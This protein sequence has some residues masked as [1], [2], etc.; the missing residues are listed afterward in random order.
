MPLA[1]LQEYMKFCQSGPS[2]LPKNSKVA[3]IAR[4]MQKSPVGS[5]L[6]GRSPA[7]VESPKANGV[8]V[9]AIDSD[10]QDGIEEQRRF[11]L[12]SLITGFKFAKD[13]VDSPRRRSPSVLG[14]EGAAM[15]SPTMSRSGHA[16]L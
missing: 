12:R 11:L 13:L 15:T 9:L 3:Q 7:V 6:R 5:P 1:D 16:A 8:A 4:S 10:L 14:P 2:A